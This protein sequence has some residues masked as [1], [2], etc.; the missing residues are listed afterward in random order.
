MRL[1][2]YESSGASCVYTSFRTS[3]AYN[4]PRWRLSKDRASF[5]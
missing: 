4:D 1:S 5:V 3:R 2:S